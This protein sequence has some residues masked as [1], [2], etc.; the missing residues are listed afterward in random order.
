MATIEEIIK[1]SSYILHKGRFVY[2]KLNAPIPLGNHFMV[3][4]DQDEVT[5]VTREENMN[6][7]S[8]LERNKDFYRLIELK[9]L[10]LSM[11]LVFWQQ[12]V[13]K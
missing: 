5:V 13:Q 4:Q 7:I 1:K 2:A 10:Y 12:S 6:Q 9:S 8:L 3:S 11:L